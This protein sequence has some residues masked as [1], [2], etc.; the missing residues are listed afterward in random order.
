[1]MNKNMDKIL[2][3][4]ESNTGRYM[5]YYRNFLRYCKIQYSLPFSKHETFMDLVESILAKEYNSKFNIMICS[6]PLH[7]VGYLEFESE[8]DKL[9][10][11]LTW[12]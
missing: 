8:A 3:V 9:E 5:I 2:L 4:S 12:S 7:Y 6:V 11:L 1:M 10:F